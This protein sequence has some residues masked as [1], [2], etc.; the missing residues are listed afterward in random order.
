VLFIDKSLGTYIINTQKSNAKTLCHLSLS[1][2]NVKS[3]VLVHITN[4]LHE[5]DSFL[6][7]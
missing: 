2:Q 6:R 3:S 4:G 7:S 1:I 5:E